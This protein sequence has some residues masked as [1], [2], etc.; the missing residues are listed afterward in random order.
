MAKGVHGTYV[1]DDSA[2]RS[3]ATIASGGAGRRRR[4]HILPDGRIQRSTRMTQRRKSRELVARGAALRR[5]HIVALRLRDSPDIRNRSGDVHLGRVALRRYVH[6]YR[7]N[8][9]RGRRLLQ[10]QPLTS[11]KRAMALL[12]TRWTGAFLSSI[13]GVFTA[14]RH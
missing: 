3:K 8:G 5:I 7:T 11:S 2:H 10:R 14:E 4:K 13:L 1:V 12:W 9:T 6:E